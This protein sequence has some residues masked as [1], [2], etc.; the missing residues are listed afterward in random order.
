MYVVEDMLL[1]MEAESEAQKQ[2][3]AKMPRLG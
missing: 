1:V 2:P 3:A